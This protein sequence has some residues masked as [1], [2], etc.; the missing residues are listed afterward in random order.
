ML[1]VGGIHQRHGNAELLKD[2]E[3]GDPVNEV[4]FHGDCAAPAVLEPV[5]Q[6]VKVPGEGAEA[7]DR[8]RIPVRSDS[9]YV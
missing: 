8:F 7:A 9:C 1:R 6:A 2:L 4:G 3:H 5:G